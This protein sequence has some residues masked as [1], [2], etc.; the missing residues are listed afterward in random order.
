MQRES[1]GV[2]FIESGHC[3]LG[4]EFDVGMHGLGDLVA[5]FDESGSN[6]GSAGSQ[7]GFAVGVNFFM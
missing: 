2:H 3:R 6:V 4:L 1:G 7:E 5:G